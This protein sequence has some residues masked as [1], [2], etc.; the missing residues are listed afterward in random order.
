MKEKERRKGFSCRLQFKLYK[1]LK[2]SAEEDRRSM[3]RMLNLILEDYFRQMEGRK[4]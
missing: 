3:S 1:E 4:Y 2:K